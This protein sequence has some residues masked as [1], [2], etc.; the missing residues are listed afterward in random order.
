L[1]KLRA[2]LLK[3]FGDMPAV[4]K[5]MRMKG[6]NALCPCRTCKILGIRIPNTR[7]PIHYVPLNRSTHPEPGETPV[8]DP[9]NLPLRNHNEMITQAKAIDQAVTQ[10]A[11]DELAK[12]SGI[13]GTSSFSQLPSVTFPTSFP[14]DFMHLVWEN[15]VP[16]L[17]QLL[18]GT[19]KELGC[20]EFSITS[21]N[22]DKIGEASAKSGATIPSSYGAKVPDLAQHMGEMTAESW[23]FWTLYLAPILLHGEIPR[24]YYEH[25]CR[26]V[27][28]LHICL[29]YTITMGQLTALKTEFQCWVTEYERYK[30]RRILGSSQMQLAN[31][32]GP[33]SLDSITNMILT[34]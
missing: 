19:F 20:D 29:S 2:H 10:T 25:F 1:F 24:P 14:I 27:E 6:H 15:T 23:S 9:A 11:S 32:Y 21:K 31:V 17:V 34:G 13:K 22:W 5:L 16:N 8:Y 4:A 7:N 33:S 26:L 12:F 3:A 28:L 30:Y 18:T